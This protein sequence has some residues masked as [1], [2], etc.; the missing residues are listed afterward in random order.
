MSSHSA[1]EQT[2]SSWSSSKNQAKSNPFQARPF[3]TQPVQS[4]ESA[5]SP[6]IQAHLNKSKSSQ[7]SDLAYISLFSGATPSVPPNTSL[8]KK[9]ISNEPEQ[10]KTELKDEVQLKSTTSS[11]SHKQKIDSTNTINIAE[12][13]TTPDRRDGSMNLSRAPED[14]Q[15]ELH[16]D[17]V[18]PSK[19]LTV[20]DEKRLRKAS[21]KISESIKAYQTAL[22]STQQLSN[23]WPG[24]IANLN[25]I[26]TNSMNTY[27][28]ARK[29][30]DLVIKKAEKIAAVRDAILMELASKA[31]GGIL[32][33]IPNI[34]QGFS[35]TSLKVTEG[36]A[37]FN[38]GFELFEINMSTSNAEAGDFLKEGKSW[39]QGASRGAFSG[40]GA[41]TPKAA[42]IKGPAW[43]N[44]MSILKSCADLTTMSAKLVGPLT[45]LAKIGPALGEANAKVQAM[46]DARETMGRSITDLE[47][48]ANLLAAA[49]GGIKSVGISATAV[50]D[51]IDKAI[52]EAEGSA[53]NSAEVEKEIWVKWISSL[54]GKKSDFLDEDTIE[55]RLQALGVWKKLGVDTGRYT[56]QSD[57]MRALVSA[58]AQERLLTYRGESYELHGENSIQLGQNTVPATY[59]NPEEVT[60]HYRVTLVGTNA[61]REVPESVLEL[62]T[63][64]TA[65]DHLIR[66]GGITVVLRVMEDLTKDESN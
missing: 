51:A 18:R 36:F 32:N 5:T 64:D 27:E 39:L 43:A 26:L 44:K 48:G 55:G 29:K 59:E 58:K 23:Q 61:T 30:V 16:S 63:M 53:P 3:V 4:A 66:T 38:K 42:G 65:V 52:D 15:V 41:G 1:A 33:R 54:T 13:L 56:S 25:N 6:D 8:Q 20:E 40:G 49:S 11:N 12:H 57:Q 24:K 46:F 37:G 14:S 10:D 2:S 28:K 50:L 35:E 45:T 17:I 9:C 31:L 62:G 19:Q 22:Q 34:K 47:T 21:Q 7:L 60:T